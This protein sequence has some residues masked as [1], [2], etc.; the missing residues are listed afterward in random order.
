M[1]YLGNRE[2]SCF[3]IAWE[4]RLRGGPKTLEQEAAYTVLQSVDTKS[5][6]KNDTLNRYRKEP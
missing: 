6:G 5:C 3:S 1:T 4:Q 2:N